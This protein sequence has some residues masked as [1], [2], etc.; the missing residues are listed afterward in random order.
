MANSGLE[1]DVGIGH[2][3]VA[4]ELGALVDAAAWRR[5]R[6]RG[7]C[8]GRRHDRPASVSI[9]SVHHQYSSS[10]SPFQANTGTPWGS[11]GVP[12]GPDGDGGGGVVLRREDVAAAPTAPRPRARS[13]SRSAPRSGWSCAA[14]R[15]CGRR[16]AASAARAP[17]G[18]PAGRASRAR[19]GGSRAGRTGRATGRRRGSRGAP[20]Q[21]LQWPSW[22]QSVR[23]C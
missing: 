19:R 10:V 3:T 7:S 5:R 12:F 21:D 4:L 11:S 22:R 14:T 2:L 1:A 8:S 20:W 17:C 23:P 9:C 6:R 16:P 13:A 18:A 15:R